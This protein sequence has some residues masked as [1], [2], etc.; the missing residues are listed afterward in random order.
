MHLQGA[1]TFV[2]RGSPVCSL[3]S[4]SWGRGNLAAAECFALHLPFLLSDLRDYYTVQTR[5]QSPF[6]RVPLRAVNLQN[7]IRLLSLYIRFFICLSLSYWMG[8]K[9]YIRALST[10]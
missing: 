10:Y 1:Q 6:D 3:K 7:D 9:I 2:A 4:S 5:F 8:L